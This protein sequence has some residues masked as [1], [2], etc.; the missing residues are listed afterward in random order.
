MN[1]NFTKKKKKVKFIDMYYSI[2]ELN[3]FKI[4]VSKLEI[5]QI[6]LKY[7]ILFKVCFGK[8]ARFGIFG[9]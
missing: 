7:S 8:S 4:F 5:L 2:S 3:N 9:P 1:L 6:G